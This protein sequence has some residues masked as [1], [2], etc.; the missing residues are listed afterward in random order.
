MFAIAITDHDWFEFLR[1]GQIT[2]CINFWT[3]SPWNIRNLQ[4]GDKF[5]FMRKSPIR[6]IGGGGT[7]NSY[8]VMSINEAWEKYGKGNGC[9]NRNALIGK[10]RDYAKPF[11]PKESQGLHRIGCIELKDCRPIYKKN[12]DPIDFNIDIPKNMQKIKYFCE[13]DSFE[14]N[15]FNTD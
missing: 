12:L 14:S 7:F 4:S 3:P 1:M 8:S 11:K 9:E 6:K 5:Y 10:I 2:N 15:I 13:T